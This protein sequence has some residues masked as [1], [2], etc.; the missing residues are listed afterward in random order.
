MPAVIE[1]S[2]MSSICESKLLARYTESPAF[3]KK[4]C[5]SSADV[6]GLSTRAAHD[7]QLLGHETTVGSRG[8]VP[9]R[10]VLLQT[11]LHHV[12]EVAAELVPAA[13]V[14]GR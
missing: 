12:L 1:L 13:I 4:L 10:G 7:G 8:D 5:L 11:N 9:L 14:L 2:P 6:P 3:L